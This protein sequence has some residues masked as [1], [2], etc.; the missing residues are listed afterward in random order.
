[1]DDPILLS[2][3]KQVATLTINRERRRNSLDH[4]AMQALQKALLTCADEDVT[5]MVIHGAGEAS[6]CAGDDVKAYAERSRQESTRHHERGLEVFDAIENH[7]CMVIAA[8]EGFC[9]G[10]GLELALSCDLRIASESAQFGLP[11]VRKLHAMPSW[12]GLTR[13]PKV[14][15]IGR[16]KQMVLLGGRLSAAEAEHQGLIARVVPDGEAVSE[17]T[18]LATEYAAAVPRDVV[19]FAKRAVDQS[20]VAGASSTH[21][22]NLLVERSQTFEG[23]S[24]P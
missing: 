20:F 6:F 4:I 16:A 11:E 18:A 1:M 19:T 5:V 23:D 3:D 22:M 13:L 10:G 24:K 17:A 14:V 2:I 12:G 21:F 7:P 9:L 8:I 15:G